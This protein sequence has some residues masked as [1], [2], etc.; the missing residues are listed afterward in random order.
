LTQ[1]RNQGERTIEAG[2][3]DHPVEAVVGGRLYWRAAC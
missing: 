2:A 3:L 1:D